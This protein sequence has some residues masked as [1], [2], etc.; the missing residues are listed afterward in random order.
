MRIFWYIAACIAVI[1]AAVA[2]WAALT[3]A[4]YGHWIGAL[5]EGAAMM[6]FFLLAAVA[7]VNAV[8][9]TKSGTPPIT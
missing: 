2:A 6:V 5:F 7:Y 4:A 8:A 3:L 9:K 1:F